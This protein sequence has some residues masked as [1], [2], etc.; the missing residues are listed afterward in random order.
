MS[1][2]L[3][4]PAH[5]QPQSCSFGVAHHTNARQITLTVSWSD[6]PAQAVCMPHNTPAVFVFGTGIEIIAR[7]L[8]S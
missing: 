4:Q 8:L 6:V 5:S 7:H 2:A 1:R 3:G